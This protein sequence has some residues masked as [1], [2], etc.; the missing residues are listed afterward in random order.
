[1]KVQLCYKDENNGNRKFYLKDGQ[2]TAYSFACGYIQRAL[3]IV[4]PEEDFIELDLWHE[5]ACY[6]VR[7]YDYKSKGRLFWDSYDTLGEARKAF[8]KAKA[9][10]RKE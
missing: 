7:A 4:K 1:M 5:G 3:F 2:L 8:H 9:Q 10:L 6:H